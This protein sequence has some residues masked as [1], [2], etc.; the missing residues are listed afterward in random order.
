MY[1]NWERA[2]RIRRRASS[3]GAR[4]RSIDRAIARGA[5]YGLRTSRTGWPVCR[6]TSRRLARSRAV[7]H[8]RRIAEQITLGAE[9][10]VHIAEHYLAPE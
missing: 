1:N 4:S 10:M 3:D 7:F 9:T 5:D 2:Q 8:V 6:D